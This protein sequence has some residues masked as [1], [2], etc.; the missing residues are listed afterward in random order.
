M[1]KYL[2]KRY[3]IGEENGKAIM[4]QDSGFVRTG[5]RGK[6]QAEEI[7]TSNLKLIKK[8]IKKKIAV[9]E[10]L[11]FNTA[12][13]RFIKWMQSEEYNVIREFPGDTTIEAYFIDLIKEFLIEKTYFYF[14]F[15]DLDLV[16][17]FVADVCRKYGIPAELCPEIEIFVREKLEDKNKVGKIK[18]NFKE[19]SKLKTY[20]YTAIH[21]AVVDFE[22][23]YNIKKAEPDE[24]NDMDKFA[25][26]SQGPQT[27]LELKEIKERVKNLDYKEKT[28]YRLYYFENIVNL[29]AIARTLKT[30]RHKAKKILASAVTKVLRGE[31]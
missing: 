28:A 10:P 12:Y 31:V 17:N 29:S 18:K 21:Y 27:K 20:L 9:Y 11:Q 8:T 4:K 15:E 14:L 6:E 3:N 24:S 23:K 16:T 13:L 19:R 26:P 7:L 22:R 5:R 1:D 30:S 2:E 25:S